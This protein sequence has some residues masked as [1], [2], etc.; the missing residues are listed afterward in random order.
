MGLE[1]AKIQMC[2]FQTFTVSNELK[3][4]QCQVKQKD[5]GL[6]VIEFKIWRFKITWGF[7]FTPNNTEWLKE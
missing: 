5:F 2:G 7:M 1:N 6:Y 3:Y 4:T